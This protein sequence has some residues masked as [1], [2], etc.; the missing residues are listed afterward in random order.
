MP[1]EIDEFER[2]IM[3]LEIERQALKKES[4]ER[5]VA[6]LEEVEAEIAESNSTLAGL[7]ARWERERDV[8]TQIQTAKERLD[9]LR[10]EEE[11]AQRGGDLERASMLK[12]RDIP[13][14]DK[15]LADLQDRL[16]EQ[17]ER[18]RMLE[19]SVGE[20]AVAEVVA[21]WTG[22]PVT[23]MLEGENQK[24]LRMEDEL[25]KRVVNQDRALKLVSSAVRRA[26][27]GLQDPN[28]PVGSFVFLGPTGVGKTELVRALASFLFNDER[29]MVRI[30][31]S[32]YM[33][34]HSVARL[35][36]A[37]PGYVGHDDGGQLTEAVR[38]R[39]YSVI[40]F[41][42]IE[43][44][45]PDVFNVLLQVLDEGRLTDG[46]GRTV[47][48]TNAIL[49][50]TSNLGS[51]LILEH[52][53]GDRAAMERQVMSVV[54]G[55]FRPEFLNRIDD[56]VI[57]EHLRKEDIAEIVG[58]QFARV[59]ERLKEKGILVALEDSA[60][61]QLAEWGYDPVYGARPLKRSIQRY[62]VD[63][64]A[65]KLIAGELAKGDLVCVSAA[66]DALTFDIQAAEVTSG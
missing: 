10:H 44:A 18:G 47:D 26:R 48:L 32:E 7:R 42:E 19:E 21:A 51:R 54:K 31:M 64:L 9:H 8:I 3:T 27:S 29:A 17:Q 35:I 55:H 61:L 28:R 57:F 53:E 59:A 14:V 63:V 36:G 66:D 24:L 33:E 65:N 6:R 49:V 40:L 5:S 13:E 4:D 43:K 38:R 60:R 52:A 25:R 22:V 50:M 62:V 15:Q 34:K 16:K 37:P 11:I 56:I 45:H 39:P 41:D 2:R 20:E 23:K 58:I 1:R 46:K 12:F 30:D